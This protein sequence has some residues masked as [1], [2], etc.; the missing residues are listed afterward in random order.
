MISRSLATIQMFWHG[1]PLSRIE[2]LS[3]VSFMRNGHAVELYVY[4]EPAGVPPGVRVRDAAD[5]L[6]RSD[7]FMHKRRNSIGHFADWFRYELLWKRGGFWSD[8]DIVCLAPFDYASPIVFAWQDEKFLN[9]AVLALPAGD[10]LAKWMADSC[11]HP[12]RWLPYDDLKTRFHKVKRWVKGRGREYVRW[13][14][15]GPYG[16]TSAARHLDY[17]KHALPRWH[18]YPV[19]YENHHVLFESGPLTF[20]RSRAVHIWNQIIEERGA[21]DRNARFPADSPFEQLWA[22]YMGSETLRH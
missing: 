14:N 1:R 16:L 5:I 12:N 22:R 6:P 13:G 7:V 2:Q 11:R 8:A 10:A 20:D 21:L 19:S 4:E 3:M 9:N 18:F 17:M 15:T